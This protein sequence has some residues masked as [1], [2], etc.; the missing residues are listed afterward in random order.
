[1]PAPDERAGLAAWLVPLAIAL[2]ALLTYWPALDLGYIW[3]D[4][5]YLVHNR[6]V[7][8]PGSLGDIWLSY[9]M[10]QYY[11]LVFTSFWLEHKLWGLNPRGY[12]AV[13]LGLHVA[14]ALILYA[15]VGR[16]YRPLRAAAALVFALHPVQVETVAWVTERKNL[17][18]LLFFLITTWL[19]LDNRGRDPGRMSYWLVYG[20]SLWTFVAALLSKSIAVSWVI[21]PLLLLWWRGERLRRRHLGEL[22]PFVVLGGLSGL[23]TVLLELFRV[24]ARG[25]DWHLGTW[26][27]LVLPGMI[28]WFY[29]VKLVWPAELMFVYPR[30]ELDAGRPLQWLPSLA[31]LAALALLYLGRHRLGRGAFALAAFYVLSLGPALGF[32]NVYPMRYSFVADHF[33]YLSSAAGLLLLI[34]AARAALRRLAQAPAWLPASALAVV[35]ALLALQTRSYLPAYTDTTSLWS[36]VLSK[37]P[38]AWIA[39]NNLGLDWLRAGRLDDA[40][41]AFERARELRPD[42]VEPYLNL[43]GVEQRRGR[44]ERALAGYRRALEVDDDEPRVHNNL[45]NVLLELGRPDEAVASY[46]RAVELDER[47]H[48][49]WR[50][51]GRA[52]QVRGRAALAVEALNRALALDGR[53]AMTRN[54]LALAY[55]ELGRTDEAIAE[56][57]RALA[58]DPELAGAHINLGKIMQDKGRRREA[59]ARYLQAL[60]IDPA[61]PIA[62]LNLGILYAQQGART[63]AAEHLRK[64][65]AGGVELTPDLA[66]LAGDGER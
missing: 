29:V 50:N 34:A 55:L 40:E 36:D 6:A 38:K 64:A 4:D 30:F 66:A 61:Q 22:A 16:L 44:R 43:A 12:H 24:G 26:E 28:I 14:C 48:I 52:E 63:P 42:L 2:A 65:R 39:H 21:V 47:F 37:N 3:D 41:A 51:L 31:V 5:S 35:A 19:H 46:R 18:A 20:L 7:Q 11:P 10:P 25:G 17:L 53:D 32:F 33:Q 54:H 1:M 56:L 9:R 23:N 60:A 62:H 8:S 27:H 59:K 13:N 45:G 57:K 49:A 58:L 15:V